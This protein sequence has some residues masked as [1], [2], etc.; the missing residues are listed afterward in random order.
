MF[1]TTKEEENKIIRFNEEQ[2]E[3]HKKEREYF[4]SKEYARSL[5]IKKLKKYGLFKLIKNRL[6]YIFVS[7]KRDLKKLDRKYHLLENAHNDRHDT[8]YFNDSKIAVY[9]CILG[10]YDNLI[11]PLVKPDNIDYFVFADFDIP[12]DSKWKRIDINSVSGIKDLSNVLKNRYVK[13]NPHKLFPDYKYSI[14]IDGNIKVYSDL[15]E[16]VNRLSKYGLSH[17]K[18]SLRKSSYEEADACKL[19]R[20]ESFSVIDAY[21]NKLKA[22]GFPDNY[23]LLECSFIVREHNKKECINIMEQWWEEFKNNVKRDQIILPY[24][25]YKNSIKTDEVSTLGANIEE[26]LS[27]E[28]IKHKGKE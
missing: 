28:I 19:L 25:L 22:A 8:N 12:N 2:K 16:H 6:D 24:I 9:T 10:N 17:F 20:K 7:S 26:D 23:G 11:E 18:H 3:M 14:Y 27:F 13:M 4:L 21:V 1:T 15:T 5:K